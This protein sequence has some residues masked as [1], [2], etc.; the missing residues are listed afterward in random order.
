MMNQNS[1]NQDLGSLTPPTN[2][3]Q[4]KSHS[5]SMGNHTVKAGQAP[6]IQL[7]DTQTMKMHGLSINRLITQN[8]AGRATTPLNGTKLSNMSK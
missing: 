3:F 2:L 8:Q 5:Y 1:P 6:L 4:D 7:E